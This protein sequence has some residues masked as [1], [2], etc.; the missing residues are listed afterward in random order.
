MGLV[1]ASCVVNSS[2]PKLTAKQSMAPLQLHKASA[3]ADST[4]VSAA[5]MA[6]HKIAS[7]DK[8]MISVE[9]SRVMG[10]P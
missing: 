2:N 1:M 4:R 7:S 5:L 10:N 3:E 8:L 9:G 6:Q